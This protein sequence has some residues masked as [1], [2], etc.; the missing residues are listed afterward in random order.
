MRTLPSSLLTLAAVA[1]VFSCPR[2]ASADAVSFASLPVIPAPP[3]R[4]GTAGTAPVTLHTTIPATEH[5]DGL[6]VALQPDKIRKPIE[7]KNGYHYV[8]IFTSDKAAQV[9]S[10]QGN[11]VVAYPDDKTAPRT[12]VT[13]GGSLGERLMSMIRTKPYVP[14]PPSASQIARLK[15]Q[16]RWPPPPPKPV[17]PV[18]SATPPHDPFQRVSLEKVTV[19]GDTAKVELTDAL[20]DLKTLGSRLVNN[21]ST[22]LTR[23]ATGPSGLGIFASRD[24]K[25][26]IQ[27]LVTSPD[28]PASDADTDRQRML[29]NL[30]STAERVLAQLPSGTSSESGCGHVRFTMAATKPGS[31]QMATILATAFLPPSSDPDEASADDD[32]S[33]PGD[34]EDSSEIMQRQAAAHQRR[35]QRARPVAVNVS[36]SQLV[37]EQDPVVS[38]SFGWAGK[39]ELLSF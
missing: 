2:G 23:V 22:T 12:C 27:F 19:T 4:A 10:A 29:E 35:T 15:A 39:D 32:Q 21:T 34:D 30:S 36:V 28:L 3:P 25:G 31:G 16:H 7:D 33:A 9:Y 17:K 11:T 18:K 6:F 24:D 14:P 1:V 20:V 37:S 26:Q 5:V 8:G 38:L 13:A